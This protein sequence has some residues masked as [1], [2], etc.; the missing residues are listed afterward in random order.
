MSRTS[1]ATKTPGTRQASTECVSDSGL[2]NQNT[3]SA[4]SCRKLKFTLSAD[5]ESET[6]R[7][8]ASSAA[9]GAQTRWTV[10]WLDFLISRVR[11]STGNFV[12]SQDLPSN[13]DAG[14]L[15]NCGCSGVHPSA[16]KKF[17]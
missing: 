1:P 16:G 15:V 12:L 10:N 3:R 9:A 5:C 7:P 6:M 13:S 11:F 8:F 17:L 4:P 14:A 2:Q